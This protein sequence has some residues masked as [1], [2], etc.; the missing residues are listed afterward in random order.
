MRYVKSLLAG[1]AALA[2]ASILYFCFLAVSLFREAPPGT[3]VGV[4]VQSFLKQPFFWLI[5]VLT[6]AIGFYWE[7]RRA[8]AHL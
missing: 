1:I 8:S 7:F 2:V 6:F 4:D 5:L 3:V